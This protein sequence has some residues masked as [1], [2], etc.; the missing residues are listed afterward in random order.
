MM[1]FRRSDVI[2]TDFFLLLHREEEVHHT[3]LRQ[4]LLGRTLFDAFPTSVH[5]G[6]DWIV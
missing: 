4:V 6:D 2:S 3:T 5:L 1:H